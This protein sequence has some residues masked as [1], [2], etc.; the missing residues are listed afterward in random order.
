MKWWVLSEYNRF[1]HF[2]EKFHFMMGWSDNRVFNK[3][4]TACVVQV[5]QKGAIF[6]QGIC[7]LMGCL[8]GR[9]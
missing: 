5:P 9:V 8:Q 4:M 1:A 6:E 7:F 2:S 3:K